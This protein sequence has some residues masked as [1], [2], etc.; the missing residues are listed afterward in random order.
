[1]AAVLF[2][3]IPLGAQSAELRH[4]GRDY[5]D[6]ATAGARLGMQ[7][8]WLR[9]HETFRLRSR[10]TNLDFG[11]NDKRVRLNEVSVYLGFPTLL[12]GERLYL[13]KADYQHVLQSI[14]TPQVFPDS[15]RLR[16][17]VIDP[18]HGG[19][20]SGARNEVYRLKEKTVNL[21]VAKRLAQLLRDA[22]YEV[23][24]TRDADIFLPLER[25]A[26][27]ANYEKAD[28]FISIHFNAA[29]NVHAAGVET[30]ILTPQHQA[31]S[32]FAKPTQRDNARFSG[33]DWDPW[34]ALIG[35]HV[36]Q[37]LLR[38]VGAA[39]RGLKR[40]RFLVLKHL[41]CPGLLLELGFLSH[42]PSAKR[43]READYRQRLAQSVFDGVRAYDQRLNRIQ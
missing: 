7:G 40:A 5:I 24:L 9:G 2:A 30:F 14:L 31:S 16:R 12:E 27:I 38:G 22:G 17:I 15:P 18:G 4:E 36:Q 35:Y 13:S 37:S 32:K 42:M 8:Y 10:W 41:E 21:D 29:G 11:K 25:R 43:I 34:N 26:R 6:L 28:L 19:Q 33:N 20:D 1:M 39:D 3:S 23:I